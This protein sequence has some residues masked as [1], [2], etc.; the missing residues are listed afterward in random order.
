MVTSI[1]VDVP[2]IPVT[3]GT[4]LV[5]YKQ[6]NLFNNRAFVLVT[7][8]ILMPQRSVTLSSA[9]LM[10]Q[11]LWRCY[12]GAKRRLASCCLDNSLVIQTTW[13]Y[14][15][16]TLSTNTPTK[17]EID[18]INN[19]QGRQKQKFLDFLFFLKKENEQFYIVKKLCSKCLKASSWN[20]ATLAYK[21]K[22][23]VT[24]NEWKDNMPTETKT[25]ARQQFQIEWIHSCLSGFIFKSTR[26]IKC[27]G[28]QTTS[29][30]HD[31]QIARSTR[32]VLQY[33]CLSLSPFKKTPRAL[34]KHNG[35]Q[36]TSCKV[37]ARLYELL[38]EFNSKKP[39]GD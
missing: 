28:N 23:D 26:K 15:T 19:C 31:K 39:T 8:I 13:C 17:T 29:K 38:V 24:G 1:I 34:T 22:S 36:V 16:V 30:P 20:L 7:T 33:N 10:S 25:L 21:L 6:S 14:Y 2:V 32:A 12:L 18:S 37:Y 35:I 9:R 3:V 27:F 4:V 5:A 11:Y